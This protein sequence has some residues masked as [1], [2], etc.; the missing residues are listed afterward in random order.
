MDV[1]V[2]G[3]A[4]GDQVVVSIHRRVLRPTHATGVHM[5]SVEIPD[6]GTDRTPLWSHRGLTL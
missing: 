5:M 4:Q 6:P 2:A 3:S 1:S